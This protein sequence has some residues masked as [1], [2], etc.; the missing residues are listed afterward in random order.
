MPHELKLAELA[1]RMNESSAFIYAEQR[2]LVNSI[3]C[4]ISTG[5]MQ[6]C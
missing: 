1:L 3:V 6:I 2:M 5:A 4:V